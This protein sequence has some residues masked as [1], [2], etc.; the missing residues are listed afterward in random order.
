LYLAC[1][2]KALGG[3]GKAANNTGHFAHRWWW[4][5]RPGGQQMRRFGLRANSARLSGI[6]K[7][8]GRLKRQ[9]DNPVAPRG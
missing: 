6:C 3:F 2:C 5:K 9:L 8:H 4:Q 1:R 7:G